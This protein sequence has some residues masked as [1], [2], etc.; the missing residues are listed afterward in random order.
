V[1][2]YLDSPDL[3]VSVRLADEDLH[4][5]DARPQSADPVWVLKRQPFAWVDQA[6]V[7]SGIVVRLRPP[8]A[9]LALRGM[10]SGF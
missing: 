1:V 9:A 3:A 7:D 10:A 6:T 8:G 4:S 2:L 5:T